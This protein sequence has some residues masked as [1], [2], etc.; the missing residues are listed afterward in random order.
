M[1][2]NRISKIVTESYPYNKIG[3]NLIIFE[4]AVAFLGG[5]LY[6]AA[7]VG[8]AHYTEKKHPLV[9][10]IFSMLCAASQ[11]AGIGVSIN[12]IVAAPFFVAGYGFGTY[13]AVSLKKRWLPESSH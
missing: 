5:A 9:A 7:C 12:T 11:V 8:W 3:M 10:S 6:E 2:L 4:C 13:M 1:S